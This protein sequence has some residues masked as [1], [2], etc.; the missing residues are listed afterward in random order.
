MVC[1]LMCVCFCVNG[2]TCQSLHASTRKL[3]VLVCLHSGL[4]LQPQSGVFFSDPR[5]NL[6]SS[7]L[8][9]LRT[10]STFCLK[11]IFFSKTCL[12]MFNLCLYYLDPRIKFK[13]SPTVIN[14][15]LLLSPASLASLS[16]SL[17]VGLVLSVP[18]V[19]GRYMRVTGCAAQE[20]THTTWHVSRATHVRGSCPQERSLVWWRRRSCVGFTTTPWLRTSNEQLRVVSSG[21][22]KMYCN[23]SQWLSRCF[24]KDLSKFVHLNSFQII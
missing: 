4:S 2:C 9:R 19:G 10:F 8:K 14:N 21:S 1:S 18:A 3:Q 5:L 11:S 12:C 13:L 22:G 20:E 24:L 7:V 23:A 15:S 16:L 17:T 6:L